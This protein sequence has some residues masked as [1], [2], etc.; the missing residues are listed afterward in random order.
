MSP[1]PP[2]IPPED[3][4][5]MTVPGIEARLIAYEKLVNALPELLSDDSRQALCEWLEA[6]QTL[7]DG[8]EDPGAVMV[9]GL[10]TELAVAQ[11]FRKMAER[12]RGDDAL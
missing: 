6:R 4:D 12:L 3:I 10:E 1:F 8:Q 9:E 5:A 7:H 2:A 11:T